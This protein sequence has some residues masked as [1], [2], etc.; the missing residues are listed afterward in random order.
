MLMQERAT[1]QPSRRRIRGDMARSSIFKLTRWSVLSFVLLTGAAMLIYPGGTLRNPSTRGY[2]FFENFLS[3]L[4]LTIASNG[5]PNRMGAALFAT[6]LGVLSLS[7]GACF[8][9]LVSLYSPSRSQ[10]NLAR[11]AGFA[12]LV[13]CISLLIVALTPGNLFPSLHIRFGLLA[14]HSFPLAAL[15]F[16]IVTAREPRFS[17]RAVVGWLFLTVVLAANVVVLNWGPALDTDAGL[18]VQVT[19]Q[20]ITFLALLLTFFSE[21]Y[22]A[23]RLSHAALAKSSRRSNGNLAESAAR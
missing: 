5:E 23:Q 1:V 21:S 20:K 10:G 2:S 6:G 3:H 18:V 8:V 13:S 14:F 4:G 11:A 15:L 17:R 7:L 19:A 12:G 22:E 16:T 9:A